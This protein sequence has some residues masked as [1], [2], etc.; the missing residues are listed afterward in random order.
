MVE[1][2]AP[3]VESMTAY[4]IPESVLLCLRMH[5]TSKGGEKVRLPLRR[6]EPTNSL[7]TENK[8]PC[9]S[10][11]VNIS[12]RSLPPYFLGIKTAAAAAA[13]AGHW[14]VGRSFGLGRNG[15]IRFSPWDWQSCYVAVFA[16][17]S[18]ALIFS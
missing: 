6:S 1:R 15:E 13:V 18:C 4:S 14:R 8:G 5:A 12:A 11:C 10:D 17:V 3:P 7:R 16:T 2:A 9:T